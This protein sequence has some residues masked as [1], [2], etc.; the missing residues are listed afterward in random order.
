MRGA[1][2]LVIVGLSALL[3]VAIA[4]SSAWATHPP[5]ETMRVRL[6]PPDVDQ[7]NVP[8][9]DHGR[10]G[11]AARTA[12]TL[13]W[14]PVRRGPN[15]RRVAAHMAFANRAH[16][17]RLIHQERADTAAR[18]PAAPNAHRAELYQS[19]GPIWPPTQPF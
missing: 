1:E 15:A 6:S 17:T 3:S 14:L 16:D 4:A 18:S 13:D 5:T 11:G 2:M 12:R 8:L 19:E 10:R 7:R 9:L